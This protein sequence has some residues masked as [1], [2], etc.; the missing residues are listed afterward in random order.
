MCIRKKVSVIL[1]VGLTVASPI[2]QAF[3]FVEA[4]ARVLTL[5]NRSDYRAALEQLEELLQALGRDDEHLLKLR[6]EL[7]TRVANEQGGHPAEQR[8]EKAIRAAHGNHAL[9]VPTVQEGEVVISATVRGDHREETRGQM[10]SEI[11][12]AWRRPRQM[13]QR[14]SEIQAED[15][16]TLLTRLRSIHIPRVQFASVP[17]SRVVDILS[18][19]AEEHDTEGLGVNLVFV[20][21]E[22]ADPLV[23]IHLRNLSLDRVLDFITESVGFE[24]DVRRD[25]VMIRESRGIGSGLETAFFPMSRST[26]IRL[27]G[28]QSEQLAAQ[29]A[30]V[31][32]FAEG[33]EQVPGEEAAL[34]RFLQRAGVQFTTIE[35]ADLALA[36]GQLI[37][38]QTPRNLE[39]V[40][41]ILRRYSEVK[42]VEIETR[43]L[44]VQQSDLDELGFNWLVRSGGRTQ[45][46]TTT[47]FPVMQ[48]DGTPAQVF[49][50]RAQTANRRIGSPVHS[51]QGPSQLRISRAGNVLDG[52]VGSELSLLQAPPGLPN[53]IDLGLDVGSGMA[54]FSGVLGRTE[55]DFIIRA[56]QRRA[57]NDLLSAPKVTV[58]SGKTAEITVA[59]ELRFPQSF[60]AIDA[61][62]GRGDSNAGSAGVAITAG[63][64]QDFAVRNIGVEMEVTPSVEEDDSINLVLEPRVTE[65]EGF[66]E[67]GGASVAIA[68]N[69][70]VTVPSGFYQPV[71]SVRRIR[72]QVT[73]W[74]GATVV[75]GGLTREQAITVHDRVPVLGDIPLMGRLF[76]SEGQTKQ[77][78]NLLIFVTATLVTPGGTPRNPDNNAW[79]EAGLEEQAFR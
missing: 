34:R 76:R 47:G 40:R 31:D 43:F 5:Q 58:L 62:V 36:D 27:I 14:S 3:D 79:R 29:R 65:F 25:A 70:T 12:E 51:S 33:A 6:V 24:Y 66:I 15:N 26:L 71:F 56:L 54:N 1:L 46:N 28:V 73:I 45:Y 37:V 74:D 50:N 10:L 68:S 9:E 2:L 13:Q 55:V 41:N 60:G 53:S 48:P 23:G 42:Q 11:E 17:M 67:Y 63:T 44:E 30:A 64:P 7:Q 32:P 22:G 52:T 19:L 49:R 61:Q 77:K 39:R 75:M 59:Q 35:G 57:G 4:Y 69:T 21:G 78:R 18:Q 8:E 38:T 72:T 16:R 20:R